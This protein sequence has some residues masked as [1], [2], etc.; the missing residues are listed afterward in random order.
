M[1]RLVTVLMLLVAGTALVALASSPFRTLCRAAD[2]AIRVVRIASRAVATPAYAE[3]VLQF[4]PISPE[5]AA[6]LDAQRRQRRASA[7]AAPTPPAPPAAPDA[8]PAPPRPVRVEA[9]RSGNVM[10][11]GSDI[12]IEEGQVVVGNVVAVGGD[13]TVDGHVEGNVESM[14][15]DV[16]LNAT[17][18]VDGDVVCVGGTLHEEDGA[19]VGG[20]RVTAAGGK[21][22]RVGRRIRDRLHDRDDDENRRPNVM[23][24][25]IWT[26]VSLGIGW[27][28]AVL[29]PGRTGAAVET[30]R[31]EPGAAALTGFLALILAGPIG[32]ALILVGALLCITIIG[33]PLALAAWC[34]YFAFVALVWIWGYV[35]GATLFG[36][37]VARK[38]V[39]PG[40]TITLLQAALWGTGLFGAAQILNKLFHM[41]PGF[42]ALGTLVG[43][44]AWIGVGVFTMLGSGAWLHNEI[45]AGTLTRWWKNRGGRSTLSDAPGAGWT[46]APQGAPAAS[47]GAPPPSMWTPGGP[48][49]PAPPSPPANPG[50]TPGA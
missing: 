26:L 30:L 14:G 48:A 27:A 18:R 46:V 5:S 37:M 3:D 20:Q 42:G 16:Y 22:D 11:V 50:G 39:G 17:A 19:V 34:G 6:A 44:L 35:V 43:V 8:A 28:F 15:G 24:G 47:P 9:G 7:S 23:G 36:Q 25:L 33:I 10:R 31:R 12:H 40:G 21:G 45:K 38:R 29:A 32:L 2:T 49:T 1:R 13:V 41:M 4:K